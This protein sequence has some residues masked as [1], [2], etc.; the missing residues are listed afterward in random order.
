VG[1]SRQCES[2]QTESATRDSTSAKAF[3]LWFTLTYD[4]AQ[5][6]R[7]DIRPPN[8]YIYSSKT[9][10]LNHFSTSVS[11]NRPALRR[12]FLPGQ[13]ALLILGF[14]SFC[15]V[16][17]SAQENTIAQRARWMN[18]KV[19]QMHYAPPVNDDSFSIRLFHAFLDELDPY[20]AYLIQ[21]DIDELKEW[22]TQLDDM[23]K[24]GDGKF[25]LA[26]DASYANAVHRLD[27]LT[28]S[29]LA[30]AFD[31]EKKDDAKLNEPILGEWKKDISAMRESWRMFLKSRILANVFDSALDTA[32]Y[33]PAAVQAQF[34]ALEPVS[35]ARIQKQ[36]ERRIHRR[37]KDISTFVG[38]A[39]LRAQAGL[40][41]PH[42]SYFSPVDHDLFASALSSENAS[43][44]MTLSE[45]GNG[46]VVIGR[47]IPG[48]PAWRSGTLHE[49]DVITRFS[50]ALLGEEDVTLLA[51]FEADEWV[52]RARGLISV[53]VRKKS[54]EVVTTSLAK[55]KVRSDENTVKSLVLEGDHRIGYLSLPGFYTDQEGTDQLG[56]AN[57]VAKEL[58]KL[59]KENIEGVILDL[60][61][62]GGGAVKEAADLSGLFIDRGPLWIRR[63]RDNKRYTL[64]DPNQGAMY[65][66]PL[67]ILVNGASASASEFVAGTLQDHQRAII[68]GT[69]TYGKATSQIVVPLS[70]FATRDA[71]YLKVTTDRYYHLP[72]GTHQIVGIL[73]DI[74]IP[75]PYDRWINRENQYDNAFPYDTIV[76]KMYYEPLASANLEPVK[77]ASHN[78]VAQNE[79]LQRLEEVCDQLEAIRDEEVNVSLKAVDY[80]QYLWN[81]RK[82]TREMESLQAGEGKGAFTVKGSQF[83]QDLAQLDE[84]TREAQKNSAEKI[85]NDIYISECVQ[86]LNDLIQP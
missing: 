53:T 80:F 44:G 45:N 70:P 72:G 5:L 33:N 8:T 48:G 65:S 79:R 37:E 66:G 9:Q 42:T 76:K 17:L 28:H 46:E 32:D 3:Y 57:D 43:L 77:V 56:C 30:S 20:R 49:G 84:F 27:S 15:W 12:F 1:V 67:I 14:F 6:L 54:G 29:M 2:R 52:Q 39:F 64:K 50:C 83:D 75:D 63:D 13:I 86:I 55:G 23:I 34:D 60:R 7:F 18:L 51:D 4:I 85:K 31:Y 74:T 61:Y 78:R 19:Q 71:G 69:P 41:D 47:L 40:Y 58:S 16:P 81:W 10:A 62:N 36:M 21:P 11:L 73:P 22:E 68:V 59:L 82:L 35:R 24:N 38:E 25:L 26:M